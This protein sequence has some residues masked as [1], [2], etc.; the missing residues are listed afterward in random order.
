MPGL[1]RPRPDP[2]SGDG[3]NQPLVVGKINGQYGVKGWIK[4]FSYTRPPE[5]ILEYQRWMLGERPDAGD[6]DGADNG[7]N[8]R[9]VT[10]TSARRQSGRLLAKLAGVDDRDRAHDLAGKWI[11]VHPSQL[12]ALPGGEYYWSD[13]AGLSVVNQ[14]GVELG[15]VDHLV[16]TG[17]NDVLAVRRDGADGADE[18][19][20]PWTPEVIVEVDLEG[21]RIR[22]EWDPDD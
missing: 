15:V 22:V 18:R 21:G 7:S 2:D 11:A 20:L 4:V 3:E 19:L 8:W 14:D 13:L 1:A 16:E 5:Q 12:A 10:V 17:A 9:A 6:A